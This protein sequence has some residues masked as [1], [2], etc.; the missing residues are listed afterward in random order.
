MLS[1]EDLQTYRKHTEPDF[2]QIRRVVLSVHDLG[3]NTEDAIQ[4][5]IANEME[6]FSS[7]IIRFDFPVHGQRP[8]TDEYFTLENC[9]LSLMAAAEYAREQY[10]EVEDLCIFVT[11]FGAYMV[12]DLTRDWFEFQQVLVTD[13]E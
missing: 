4:T 11:G 12:L 1:R 3:G 7:V 2:G 9:R 8:M 5:G 6:I 10:P 13:W